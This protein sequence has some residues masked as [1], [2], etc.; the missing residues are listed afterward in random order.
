MKRILSGAV[1]LSTTCYLLITVFLC[2]CQNKPLYQETRVLMGTFVKVTSNS[3]SAAGIAFKEMQRVADLLSKYKSDSEI[4][5]LNRTGKLKAS[6]ETYYIIKKAEEFWRL[7]GGAFDITVG[8]LMDLWGFTDKKYRIPQKEEIQKTLARI[9]FDKIIFHEADNVIEFKISGMRLD[10]G[11]IAKGYAVDC[12]VKKLKEKGITSCLINA[13]G[14]IYCLGDNYGRPWKVA[15]RN[16]RGKG[17]FR[18]LELSNKAVATSGDYEQFFV[19]AAKRY[20]HIIDPK[21]G[22][23]VESGLISVTIVADSGLDCDAL[24]TAVFVLGKEKGD[25]LTE[26]FP[27]VAAII[28]EDKN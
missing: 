2:G 26:R 28:I 21:T 1:A 18:Y 14:Q 8:P 9:G 7:S 3:A 17:V 22:Y 15:I 6:P 16:P 27:G 10:L 4:S 24:S 13:G 25:I 20:A 11:A 5:V 19:S 12:A 23:P